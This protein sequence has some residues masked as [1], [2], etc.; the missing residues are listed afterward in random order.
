VIDKRA[1]KLTRGGVPKVK[2]TVGCACCDDTPVGMIRRRGDL[3][4]DVSAIGDLGCE[5]TKAVFVD[6]SIAIVVFSVA[7]IFS[8]VVVICPIIRQR[9]IL[10]DTSYTRAFFALADAEGFAAIGGV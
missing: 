4:G 10:P 6:A 3:L 1:N 5:R 8:P 2:L 7:A 9:T